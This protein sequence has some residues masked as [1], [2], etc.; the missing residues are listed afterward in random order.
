MSGLNRFDDNKNESEVIPLHANA[1][2]DAPVTMHGLD[3][4]RQIDRS[5]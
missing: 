2:D 4:L 5:F 3:A 1:K